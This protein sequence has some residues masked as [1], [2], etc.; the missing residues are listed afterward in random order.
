[1]GA[2]TSK[3][4]AGVSL[5][6]PLSRGRESRSGRG[7]RCVRVYYVPVRGKSGEERDVVDGVASIVVVREVGTSHTAERG[8]GEHQLEQAP[9]QPGGRLDR[10]GS[11]RLVEG[12][13]G[14]EPRRG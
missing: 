9:G 13:R 8:S 2:T 1:M 4:A 12:V 5:T 7:R 14:V 3:V 11:R 10:G 6:P